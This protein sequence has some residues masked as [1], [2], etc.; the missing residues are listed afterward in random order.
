MKTEIIIAL[1]GFLGV[2]VG[3]LV[4][5]LGQFLN[6]W[7]K[8]RP[9]RKAD[10]ARKELLLRMLNHKEHTWR[11]FDRLMHVIGSDEE[12]TK[13]LLLE[14]G[15]RASEDGQNLWGLTSRNPFQNER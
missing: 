1:F 7:L 5:V 4:G 10:D 15:A 8:D 13:R 3:A 6:Y 2:L 9:K 11:S 12:N 14:I